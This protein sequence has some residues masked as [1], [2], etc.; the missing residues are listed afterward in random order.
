MTR[1]DASRKPQTRPVYVRLVLIGC[2]DVVTL[3]VRRPTYLALL[4]HTPPN[5]I[6]TYGGGE[7]CAVTVIVKRWI[8]LVRKKG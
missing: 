6:A 5:L 8:R 2:Y 4:S 1:L 3:L 7:V